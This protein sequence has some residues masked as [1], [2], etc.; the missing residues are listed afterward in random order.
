LS[1]LPIVDKYLLGTLIEGDQ[2]VEQA[3]AETQSPVA[4]PT[5][6]S[7]I[8]VSVDSCE[9]QRYTTADLAE[10]ND[11]TSRWYSLYGVVYDFTAYMDM[12]PGGAASILWS[13]GTIA[14]EAFEMINKHYVNL[15]LNGGFSDYIIGRQGSTSGVEMVPCDE[16][17]SVA[18]DLL[19]RR[20]Q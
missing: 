17:E 14:T 4:A 2:V 13:C 6:Q 7:V 18:V 3:Q 19:G 12:H 16:V 5:S 10:H 9:M 1:Y 11:E 20:H 15:L 8:P